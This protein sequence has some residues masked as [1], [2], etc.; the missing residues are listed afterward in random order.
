MANSSYCPSTDQ[1]GFPRPVGAAPDIG[2]FEYGSPALLRISRSSE[3]E[4]E[5]FVLGVKTQW[6]RLF[7]STTLSDWQ[8]VA[9]NQF[10]ANGT[11]VFQDNCATG[12]THR[13]Y[14]VAL[15]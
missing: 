12:E 11:I 5:I 9:T 15:P 1:R 4:V 6:C 3:T 13:F 14:K 7:T 8:C 2:A 10:G